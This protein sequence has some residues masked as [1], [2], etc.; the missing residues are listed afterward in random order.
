MVSGFRPDLRPYSAGMLVASRRDEHRPRV[1][2][3]A[4]AAAPG[5]YFVAPAIAAVMLVVT[6]VW[7]DHYGI[8]LRDPDG[9]IGWRFVFV[10]ALSAA[11]G[12]S[13]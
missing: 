12:R 3:L 7:G 4:R 10:F 6:L 1:A 11:S 9:I 13:T 2:R 8:G 5:A